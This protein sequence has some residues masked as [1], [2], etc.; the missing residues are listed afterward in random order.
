MDGNT[1]DN[2]PQDDE[3][4]FDSMLD[5]CSKDLDKKLTQNLQ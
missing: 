3:A 5:D 4:D 1:Q 2:K